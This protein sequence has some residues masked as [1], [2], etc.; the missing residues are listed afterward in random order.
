M[1]NAHC[2][3]NNMLFS[4]LNYNQFKPFEVKTHNLEQMEMET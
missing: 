2:G 4:L 1:P 3:K